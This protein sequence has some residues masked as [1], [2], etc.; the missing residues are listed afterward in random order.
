MTVDNKAALEVKNKGANNGV[1]II[2]ESN[3]S[4]GVLGKSNSWVGVQGESNTSAGV[5]GKSNSWVGVQGDSTHIGIRGVA[6]MAGRFEGKV[7]VT[8]DIELLNADCAKIS[9]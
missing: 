6:P 1:G 2:G 9:I 3:T 7:Q 5:L 8:G 4:A